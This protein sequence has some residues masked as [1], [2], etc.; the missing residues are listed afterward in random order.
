MHR[1]YFERLTERGFRKVKRCHGFQRVVIT[2][3]LTGK[4]HTRFV[5]ESE[6]GQIIIE[7]FLPYTHTERHKYGVTGICKSL[8]KMFGTV[9]CS[10]VAVDAGRSYIEMPAAK[11]RFFKADEV[12]FKRHRSRK[13]LECRTGFVGFKAFVLFIFREF[14]VICFVIFGASDLKFS[15]KRFKREFVVYNIV[16]VRVEVRFRRHRKYF[17][18]VDV[19]DY[20]RYSILNVVL[21]SC[22]IYLR[23]EHR[24]HFQVHGKFYR[25]AVFRVYLTLIGKRHR[26][27]YRS[28]GCNQF[29]RSTR[30]VI[31]VK[32]FK[33]FKSLVVGTHKTENRRKR[34]SVRI[35]SLRVFGNGYYRRIILVFGYKVADLIRNVFFHAA[36]NLDALNVFERHFIYL[37]SVFGKCGRQAVAYLFAQ[38]FAVYQFRSHYD[39]VSGRA[40]RKY[41]S[42]PVRYRAALRLNGDILRLL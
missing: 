31:V 38:V 2:G 9:T 40:Y 37:V 14:F 1:R 32:I 36:H 16:F 41:V 4:S 35:I 10:L 34:V 42:V 12:F 20:A 3:L 29:S 30:Q 19:H 23:F 33:T 18:C 13:Y 15:R 39:L 21:N 8:F 11:E 6:N 17:T 7:F 24:L 26:R 27:S 22:V 5:S 28:F 25:A